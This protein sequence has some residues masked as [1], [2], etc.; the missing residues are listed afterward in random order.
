MIFQ[1]DI[2]SLQVEA[3]QGEEEAEEGEGGAEEG[4]EEV[5]KDAVKGETRKEK[6][7]AEEDEA[8]AERPR[9]EQCLFQHVQRPKASQQ[10][11]RAMEQE[12][13]ARAKLAPSEEANEAKEVRRREEQRLVQ[14]VLFITKSPKQD[15]ESYRDHMSHHADSKPAG[16]EPFAS[17]T[18]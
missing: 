13:G 4:E 6:E 3:E 2:L 1:T 16:L 14:H 9:V 11:Q 8:D 7:Q 10:E 18:D 5:L 17:C 12:Q 15:W